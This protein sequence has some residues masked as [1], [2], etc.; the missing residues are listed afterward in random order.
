MKSYNQKVQE[1]NDL[2]L[3]K[4]ALDEKGMKHLKQEVQSY[5]DRY[6]TTHIDEIITMIVNYVF[7]YGF[8]EGV[9]EALKVLRSR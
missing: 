2:V 9:C 8:H 1:I 6:P 5:L 4:K 7:T 3:T